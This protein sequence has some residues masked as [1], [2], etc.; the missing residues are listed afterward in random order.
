[1]QEAA[2]TV[3]TNLCATTQAAATVS[4]EAALSAQPLS[5]AFF[6]LGKL[7]CLPL[8][9]ATSEQNQKLR[10]KLTFLKLSL[11]DQSPKAQH[12]PPLQPSSQNEEARLPPQVL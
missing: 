10:P 1:M 8:P 3:T 9:A 5:Y 11:A 7:A 6:H 2:R 12:G 4:T